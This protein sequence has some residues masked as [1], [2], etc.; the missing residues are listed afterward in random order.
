MLERFWENTVKMLFI[1]SAM[2]QILSFRPLHKTLAQVQAFL[3]ER[4]TVRAAHVA[5]HSGLEMGQAGVR[6]ALV[7]ARRETLR[8][9]ALMKSTYADNVDHLAVIVRIPKKN[10]SPKHLL[11]RMEKT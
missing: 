3:D 7:E 10:W 4:E 11:L 1:H 6:N 5:A 9:Y 8:A 2:G